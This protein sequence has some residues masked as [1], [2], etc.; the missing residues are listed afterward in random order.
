MIMRRQWIK[1]DIMHGET[2]AAE[3]KRN[4]SCRVLD[5][6]RMLYSLYLEEG[7]DIDTQM[8]NLDNFYHWCASRVLTL[9]RQYA[10]EIL[11]VLDYLTGNTDR[12]WGN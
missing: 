7:M 12:H 11:N 10:K 6:Q 1:Y 5:T 9:D 3:V 4:G 8:Q 2:K